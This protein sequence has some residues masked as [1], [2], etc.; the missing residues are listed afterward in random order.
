[1][2]AGQKVVILHNPTNARGNGLHSDI[3]VRR[4]G[5]QSGAVEA[6][7]TLLERPDQKHRPMPVQTH[8]ERDLDGIR[9]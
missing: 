3:E 5:N 9:R 8:R 1:V 7:Y 6:K 4:S 2:G